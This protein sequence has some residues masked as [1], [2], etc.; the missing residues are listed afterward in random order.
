MYKLDKD[1]PICTAYHNIKENFPKTLWS[2][3]TFLVCLV[4]GGISTIAIHHPSL[5]A[6]FQDVVGGM[7]CLLATVSLATL[8]RTVKNFNAEKVR[9]M[10]L[11]RQMDIEKAR[12]RQMK[13]R[14]EAQAMQ[15]F[16][17]PEQLTMKQFTQH[18]KVIPI[19]LFMN[20]DDT[21]GGRQEEVGFSKTLKY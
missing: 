8:V 4:F 13:K 15:G 20:N 12:K 3:Q 18:D 10:E 14:E 11:G 7:N 16:L 9:W 19:D 1:S 2:G 5:Q 21:S 17:T 6:S